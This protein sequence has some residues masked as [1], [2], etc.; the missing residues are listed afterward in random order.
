MQVGVVRA[1]DDENRRLH[2]LEQERDQ[3]AEEIIA[4]NL[5]EGAVVNVGYD[6]KKDDIRITFTNPKKSK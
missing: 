1:H 2:V 6:S 4:T 5:T 3:L